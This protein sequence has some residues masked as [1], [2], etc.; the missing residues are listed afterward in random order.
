MHTRA[1]RARGK[2]ASFLD[3][4]A[5]RRGWPLRGGRR[6]SGSRGRSSAGRRGMLHGNHPAARGLARRWRVG[7]ERLVGRSSGTRGKPVLNDELLR[8]IDRDAGQAFAL[9][10]PAVALELSGFLLT[11][12][13]EILRF[14]REEP[15]ALR[16]LA[17]RRGDRRDLRVALLSL[18]F[19]RDEQTVHQRRRERD[20]KDQRACKRQ[21]SPDVDVRLLVRDVLV[22]HLLIGV[23]VAGL[24]RL[25]RGG[26][27]RTPP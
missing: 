15:R 6:L 13:A 17:G 23:V 5:R 22:V 24:E 4:L 18:L 10:H 26:H 1:A 27:A 16:R 25:I 9:V 21:E 2:D 3:L 12:P 7:S 19:E 8:E 20:D 14:V 11:K